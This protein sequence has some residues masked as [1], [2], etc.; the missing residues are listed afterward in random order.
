ML[1]GRKPDQE[2]QHEITK[3]FIQIPA[4]SPKKPMGQKGLLLCMCWRDQRSPEGPVRDQ[5]PEVRDQRSEVRDQR[6]EIRDQAE[7]KGN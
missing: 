7:C 1:P 6:S 5:R 3:D 2:S 4:H